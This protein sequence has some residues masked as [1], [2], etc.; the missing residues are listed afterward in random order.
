MILHS[1]FW[2]AKFL[3]VLTLGAAPAFCIALVKLLPDRLWLRPSAY[4]PAEFHILGPCGN[5]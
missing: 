5:L 3:I 4:V 2:V 1:Q